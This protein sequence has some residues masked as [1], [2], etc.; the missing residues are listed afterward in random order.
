MKRRA[1]T[2]GGGAAAPSGRPPAG[3]TPHAL[4]STPAAM[5]ADN[6]RLRLIPAPLFVR[7]PEQ[8]GADPAACQRR[9]G[10]AGTSVPERAAEGAF[11]PVCRAATIVP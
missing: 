10:Y 7:E 11:C 5:T 3:A 2:A 9:H 4:T 6:L 1:F 8:N